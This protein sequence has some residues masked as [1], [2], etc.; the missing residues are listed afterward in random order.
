MLRE[1]VEYKIVYV[2]DFNLKFMIYLY[3]Y[4]NNI[5]GEMC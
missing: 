3:I 5:F 4:I 1:K 2:N